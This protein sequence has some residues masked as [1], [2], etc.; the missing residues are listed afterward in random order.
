MATSAVRH[1]AEVAVRD[2]SSQAPA[3]FE[4]NAS[5]SAVYHQPLCLGNILSN[6]PLSD[7]RSVQLVNRHGWREASRVMYRMVSVKMMDDIKPSPVSHLSCMIG[8]ADFSTG[9]ASFYAAS[10]LETAI[11]NVGQGGLLSFA[12]PSSRW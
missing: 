7:L 11:D 12:R 9:R 8:S 3:Q 4:N 6:L 10:T 1:L 5:A 2:T